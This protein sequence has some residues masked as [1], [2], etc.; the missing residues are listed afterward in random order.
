[1]NP[2]YINLKNIIPN[3]NTEIERLIN[4]FQHNKL[5]QYLT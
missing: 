2:K 4:S 1:M 5:N 3:C